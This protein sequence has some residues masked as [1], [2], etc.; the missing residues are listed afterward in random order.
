MLAPLCVVH[1]FNGK[2][3]PAVTAVKGYWICQKHLSFKDDF[4]R[5]WE[6]AQDPKQ[7][8]PPKQKG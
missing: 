8:N 3:K 2:T 1:L 5:R 6:L 4:F 7:D